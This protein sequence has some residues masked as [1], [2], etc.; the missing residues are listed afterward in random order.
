MLF[1]VFQLGDERYAL[2]AGEVAEVL[3]LVEIKRIA[4]APAGVAG[5][6][7]L[8]GRAVPVIDLG[9]VA[10]DRPSQMRLSTRIIL[11]HYR[12]P[13]GEKRLLGL[14]AE[15]VTETVRRERADFAPAGVTSP[16]ARYLGPVASDG[17]GLLQEVLV[18][19]LL[20]TSVRAALFQ[21]VEQ[22]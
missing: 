17:R 7:N 2:D 6:F 18:D 19:E 11:V 21:E 20:P 13:S 3:P 16:G 4:R 9:L 10:F 12:D 14:V 1:L 5:V 22:Q 15:R 8:R